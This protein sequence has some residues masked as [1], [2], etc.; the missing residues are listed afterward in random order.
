MLAK[1]GETVST[2]AS[3]SSGRAFLGTIIVDPGSKSFSLKAFKPKKLEE[4]LSEVPLG[5]MA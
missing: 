3:E 5:K 4:S 1:I 2:K